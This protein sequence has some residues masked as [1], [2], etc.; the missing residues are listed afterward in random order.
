[1]CARLLKYT[2]YAND[3]ADLLSVNDLHEWNHRWAHNMF[4]R[5]RAAAKWLIFTCFIL[6]HS[7]CCFIFSPFSLADIV[8]Y[9][10]LSSLSQ[11][12]CK[13][14]IE[15]LASTKIFWFLNLFI[16]FGDQKLISA[17]IYGR[18]KYSGEEVNNLWH[19]NCPFF[20]FAKRS[21][22]INILVRTWGEKGQKYLC[23]TKKKSSL[24]FTSGLLSTVRDTAQVCRS[25]KCVPCE[26]HDN[27]DSSPE[28]R[29]SSLTFIHIYIKHGSLHKTFILKAEQKIFLPLETRPLLYCSKVAWIKHNSSI[30][31]TFTSREIS[32]DNQT[33][34]LRKK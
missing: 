22:Y 25:L 26:E 33:I 18:I 34:F 15:R 17:F 24:N 9:N 8:S 19:N 29:N 6:H 13:K 16:F 31:E 5:W 12:S 32:L 20:F 21:I 7:L 3:Y 4:V 14:I 10:L 28:P 2:N 11:F 23:A 27:T 30:F 1:M